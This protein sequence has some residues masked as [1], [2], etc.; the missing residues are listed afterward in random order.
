MSRK[1][2]D[3]DYYGVNQEAAV[4]AFLNAKTLTEKWKNG[5]KSEMFHL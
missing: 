4:V 5:A 3:R 1:K 2:K